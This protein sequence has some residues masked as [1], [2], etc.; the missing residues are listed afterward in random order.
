MV[1][2][3]G[4]RDRA[5]RTALHYAALNGDLEQ[6]RQLLA[7][8]DASERDDDGFTPLHFAAQQSQ[9]HLIGVLVE[10]GADVDA[11]DRWG[12][13]PLWRAVFSSRG[14]GATIL[15]LLAVGAN[16]DLP[17]TSGVSP[18]SLSNTIANYPVMQ[19]LGQDPRL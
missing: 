16:P 8:R 15:A 1:S 10:A 14:E 6:T 9:A 5:G 7:T 2:S 17:N 18:R 3:D 12:D 4:S 13:T 11:Q 19:F